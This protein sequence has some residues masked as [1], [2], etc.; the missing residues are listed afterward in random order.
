MAL[1]TAPVR[2]I[3][4]PRVT[5]IKTGPFSFGNMLK[6]EKVIDGLVANGGLANFELKGRLPARLVKPGLEDATAYRLPASA[7]IPGAK[8]VMYGLRD[9]TNGKDWLE[10]STPQGHRL[11]VRQKSGDYPAGFFWS[12]YQVR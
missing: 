5:P 11:A 12:N 4:V 2:V 10:L 8:G 3:S 6:L 7:L 9:T 1:T